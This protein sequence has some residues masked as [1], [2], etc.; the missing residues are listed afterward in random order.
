M[1]PSPLMAG[2]P[3]P[4]PQSVAGMAEGADMTWTDW[5][6]QAL[7]ATGAGAHT[8]AQGS[9]RAKQRS[10][11]PHWHPVAPAVRTDKAV[12]TS[13]L[14]MT[15]NSLEVEQMPAIVVVKQLYLTPDDVQMKQWLF[16]NT[17]RR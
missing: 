13:S 1:I 4:Q 17:A 7:Q 6:E 11:P 16:F 5:L 10:N 8:G 12:R 3:P 14:F 15:R 9:R 2:A